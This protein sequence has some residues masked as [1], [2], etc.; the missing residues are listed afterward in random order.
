MKTNMAEMYISFALIMLYGFHIIKEPH[1]FELQ[2]HSSN[3][4]MEGG[5][6]K[7]LV[8]IFQTTWN[9]IPEDNKSM[10]FIFENCI[11]IT[12]CHV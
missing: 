9:H 5:T 8:L 6:S 10:V 7:M 12:Y 11:I 1:C 2:G 3:L 4:K